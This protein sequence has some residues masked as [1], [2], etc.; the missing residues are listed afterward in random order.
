LKIVQTRLPWQLGLF[1]VWLL[2]LIALYAILGRALDWPEAP[3]GAFILFT[4][5][6]LLA[7]AAA[8]VLLYSRYLRRRVRQLR[9]SALHI[10]QHDFQRIP[11]AERNQELA[12]MAE[13]LNEVAARYDR[14][15]H[16]LTEERNR[17]DTILRSMAEG[18]AVIEPGQKIVFCNEAFCQAIG[19]R[20]VPCAGRLLVEV[21]RQAGLLQLV[22]QA[23]EGNRKVTG[24]METTAVPLRT[25]AM[26]AAP[27][28]TGAATG[29][30]LVLHDITELRKLERMRRDFVANVSHEFKTP[31]TA[32]QGFAET[33]LSGALDDRQN[34][35]R[36]LKIIRDH[37]VRLSRVTNDL[38]KL[39]SIEAGK[40]ELAVQPVVLAQLVASCVETVRLKATGKRLALAAECDNHVEIS[41]DISR[42][43]EA[44]LNLLD[45]AIQYTP[46]G[47][48]VTVRVTQAEQQ[49]RIAVS[50]TGIGIPKLDQQRIFERFYRVDDA[51]SR[52]VGGT[53]L[54]LSITKHLVEA[55][56]GRIE[57]ESE[58]G[59]GSTFTIIL[60][61]PSPD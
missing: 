50:D 61:S 40:L 34:S 35:T 16:L 55:H 59:A 5:L 7:I 6:V 30:V 10:G 9:Q 28:I 27:V 57:V 48:Q 26:T 3:S 36:F 13:A 53:G 38:L 58:P 17:F 22:Q 19:L 43:R 45:N 23:L 11:V 1:L 18:V 44:L 41:A 24:E 60:P 42:L 31:L 32:I 47:G 15:I 29:V 21:T 46:P 51:R 14:T 12:G 49:A 8:P 25:Y 4:S 56:G 54:G 33:L 39:S 2:S 52:E 37:A 20:A